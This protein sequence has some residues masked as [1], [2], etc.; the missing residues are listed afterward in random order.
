M[1]L[2][3]LSLASARDI[4]RIIP[5]KVSINGNSRRKN[6]SVLDDEKD[7]NVLDF[8]LCFPADNEFAA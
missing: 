8:F 4:N 7:K 2:I 3:F 6:T 1:V 5:F